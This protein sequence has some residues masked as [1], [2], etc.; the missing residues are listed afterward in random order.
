[1]LNGILLDA[2][3]NNARDAIS[4]A[5]VCRQDIYMQLLEGPRHAVEAAYAR[6]CQDDRHLSVRTL[7]SKRVPGRLFADWAMLHDPERSWIWSEADLAGGALD[8]ASETEIGAIFETLS[9]RIGAGPV[10]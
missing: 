1:M 3:R 5:L 7:V 2:R 9:D 4:G 6:I 10:E 8:R